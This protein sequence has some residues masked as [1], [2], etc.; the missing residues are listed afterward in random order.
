MPV[1]RA[2]VDV[3]LRS[4]TDADIGEICRLYSTDSWLYLG[5]A[6]TEGGVDA[7]A[8]EPYRDRPRRG[9][10]CFLAIG[11]GEIAHVNWVCSTWGDALPGNPIRLKPV[12]FIRPTR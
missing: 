3:I 2:S 9:E 10:L 8:R 6:S 5:K 11:D 1:A 12:R 7:A 4:A